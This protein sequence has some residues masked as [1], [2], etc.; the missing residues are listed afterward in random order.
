MLDMDIEDAILLL[1]NNVASIHTVTEWADKVG[2]S[3]S[4]FTTLIRKEYEKTAHQIMCLVK[5]K[6]VLKLIEE[7]PN[8]KGWF[9]ARKAGFL[10]VK[11]LYKFLKHHFDTSLTLLRREAKECK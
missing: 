11:S 6:K 10:D 1:R 7:D 2:Y 9:I 3:R 8:Q 4:H 5:Y